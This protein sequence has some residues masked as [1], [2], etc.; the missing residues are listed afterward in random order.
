MEVNSW[1]A[2]HGEQLMGGP[3]MEV[4]SMKGKLMESNSWRVTHGG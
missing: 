1:R 2:T 3:F 4:N